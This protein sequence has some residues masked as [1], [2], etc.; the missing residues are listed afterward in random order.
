MYRGCSYNVNTAGGREYYCVSFV[1]R[2]VVSLP[3]LSLF[4]CSTRFPSAQKGM[5]GPFLLGEDARTHRDRQINRLFNR[6][7]YRVGKFVQP[8]QAL[9]RVCICMHRWEFSSTE[10]VCL[11]DKAPVAS[12]VFHFLYAEWL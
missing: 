12:C 8:T 11:P 10:R 3:H 1:K 2:V 4:G 5:K 9:E 6:A 7:L